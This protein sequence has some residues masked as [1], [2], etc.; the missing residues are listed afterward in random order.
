MR[1][2][3]LGESMTAKREAEFSPLQQPQ[4]ADSRAASADSPQTEEHVNPSWPRWTVIFSTVCDV[5]RM[6]CRRLRPTRRTIHRLDWIA[7]FACVAAI[8]WLLKYAWSY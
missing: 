1:N 3:V 7:W 2:S 5:V 8:L 6:E 4:P